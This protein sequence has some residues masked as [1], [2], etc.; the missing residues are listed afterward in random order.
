MINMVDKIL[1]GRLKGRIM[2]LE[3]TVESL[4][5]MFDE[6]LYD[7]N[8]RNEY[9]RIDEEYKNEKDKDIQF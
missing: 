1:I 8:A 3:H 2:E 5:N 4:R 6:V 9:K 7:D